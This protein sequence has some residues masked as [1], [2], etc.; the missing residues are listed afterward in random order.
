MAGRRAVLRIAVFVLT[1]ASAPAAIAKDVPVARVLPSVVSVLPEW[2]HDEGRLEEPEGTGVAIL[3]GTYLLTALHVVDKALS[4]RVRTYDGRIIKAEIAARDSAT[5]LALLSVDVRLPPLSFGGDVVLGEPV[6]AVGNAFGLGLSVSCG[7]VSA[8]HRAGI[9]FNAIEDFVQT[10][11]AVNPGASGG[12]LV[13]REGR[14]VGVLS[15]IFTKGSDANIGVN[16]AIAAPLASRVAEALASDGAV[17]WRFGGMALAAFPEQGSTGREAATVMRL[18]PG[19]PAAAAGVM[20]GDHV[21]AVGGR[22]VRSPADVRAAIARTRPGEAI[23][24]TVEREGGT[25]HLT[26]EIPH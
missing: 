6:C 5:D 26:M 15:A 24:L 10:D 3:D 14:L 20:P 8:L 23:G 22:R 17:E 13:D 7:I 11:A 18:T 1:V 16:F 21:V 25:V 12:A 9:G 4:V 19:G 2:P